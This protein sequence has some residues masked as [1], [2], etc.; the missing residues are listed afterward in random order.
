MT[1]QKNHFYTDPELTYVDSPIIAVRPHFFGIAVAVA[2]NIVR[3]DGGGEPRDV[4]EIAGRPIHHVEK[5]EGMT[6]IAFDGDPG[7]F[8]VGSNVDVQ[9][10]LRHRE[11]RRRLHTGVHLAIRCAYN[12]FATVKVAEAEIA[13][14]A[15]SAR[16]IGNVGRVV[17]RRD[18]AMVDMAMRSE[19]L[20]ARPVVATKA[21]SVE[22]AETEHGSL[23][24]VSDRHA[25]KGKVR[26]IC[27]ESFDVNPCSGLHHPNTNIGPYEMKAQ[28]DEAERGAFYVTLNLSP[29][30]MCW[31]GD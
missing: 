10:D 3:A 30:W 28:L 1:Q 6:W 19:V 7:S 11:D 12:H 20:K 5:Q 9:I 21:K 13:A 15:S 2:D 29:C 31:Y 16:I 14:D 17:E 4:G 22:H 26:L 27:I 24:R 25:F 23:F 18:I 8:P